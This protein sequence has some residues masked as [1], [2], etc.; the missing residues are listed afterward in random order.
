NIFSLLELEHVWM[1]LV[2]YRVSRQP[3]QFGDIAPAASRMIE[4]APDRCLW[5]SDWP[6]IYLEGRPMP[7][8]TDLFEA[9]REWMTPEDERRIFVDNP[10]RLYEFQAV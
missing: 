10:A 5:G 9:A 8:T 7:N 2:G 1:K 6:H 4:I 3:P